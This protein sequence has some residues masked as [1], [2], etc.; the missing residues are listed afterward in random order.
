MTHPY[1]THDSFICDTRLTHMHDTFTSDAHLIR[2][3]HHSYVATHPYLTHDSFICDTRLISNAWLIHI[4]Y[5]SHLYVASFICGDSFISDARLI[6]M[7]HTTHSYVW[8]DVF[9]CE[10]QE[11]DSM[12]AV[13]RREVRHDSFTR[14]T[15][16]IHIWHTTLSYVTHDWSM[17]TCIWERLLN[18][19][20]TFPCIWERLLS[21]G[22]SS[23]SFTSDTHLI[24][25]WHHSYVATHPYLTHDSFI[26]DTRLIHMHDTFTSDAHLI[27]MWH[28]SYVATHPYREAKTHRIP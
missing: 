13:R 16:L 3:C 2:M 27:H 6:H 14:E 15:W 9:T 23:K 7:S 1:L 4:W 25:M 10:C 26:C 22:T 12:R 18:H 19:S 24:C 20:Y 17:Y 11:D 21:I 8:R 28:H 5:T